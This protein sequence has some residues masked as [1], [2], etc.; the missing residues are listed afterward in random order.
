MRA[1]TNISLKERKSLVLSDFRGVDF[2]SS[3]LR[4]KSNRASKMRNFINEYG[5]NRKRNGWNE[6]H[7]F[8][9]KINGIFEF[10]G[11]TIVYAG[12]TF[13]SIDKGAKIA[14]ITSPK[15]VDLADNRIQ[16][17]LKKG[18]AY[19]IGCGDYLVYN[20]NELRRV[21]DDA[22]TYIPTTTI[23]IDNDAV[24]ND[25]RATLDDVNCLSS[26]RKNRLVGTAGFKLNTPITANTKVDILLETYDLPDTTWN[27][28]WVVNYIEPYTGDNFANESE[29]ASITNRLMYMYYRY[30]ETEVREYGDVFGYI[31]YASGFIEL[32]STVFVNSKITVKYTYNNRK[33]SQTFSGAE[34]TWTLDSKIKADTLVEIV[35]E[36]IESEFQYSEIQDPEYITSLVSY[37]INNNGGDR[38][39]LYKVKKDGEACEPTQCGSIDFKN[40]KITFNCQTAPQIE[41]K[42]NIIVTFYHKTDFSERITKCT[43]GTLFGVD[44]NTNRLFLS[45]NPDYPNMDFHSEEDDFTYFSDLSAAAL[46]SDEVAI[47][48]YSRLSDS[49]LVIHKESN[50]RETTIFYRTGYY[51]TKYDENGNLMSRRAIFPLK[52]G[53]I[54]E[55]CVSTYAC[56]DFAG[57]SLIL[58]PSGVYG[59]VLANNVAT[60]ERYLRERSRLIGEH[61]KRQKNLSEAVGIVYKNRYYLAVDGVCYVA[62]ARYK[63][64]TEDDVDGSYNY[65]WWYWDNIPARVWAVIDEKLYFGTEDGQIC[66]FDDKYTDRTYERIG[67]GKL[68]VGNVTFTFDTTLTISE[69]DKI[70]L[71]ADISV[72]GEHLKGRELYVTDLNKDNQTFK[73]STCLGGSALDFSGNDLT[74]IS[75]RLVNEKNVVAEWCTPVFDLGTNEASKSLLK[76]TLLTEPGINGKL[77][78]GYETRNVNK[79]IAARG[80]T[81]FSFDNLSFENFSFETGFANSYSVKCNQ[82]NFNF[83]MFRFFSDSDSDCCVN[84][85]TAIY[86]INKSNIGVM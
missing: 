23:S 7:K 53:S 42:D 30:E 2:S 18:K 58:S 51:D 61:L 65:E 60:A 3:V 57:D 75:A 31:N 38:A 67:D 33:F 43:F 15:G 69:S 86:K 71:D 50:G 78:F 64:T 77:K 40:G 37:E 72:G 12:T 46:G 83:I 79:L 62:D 63:F 28:G 9:G 11:K 29:S 19:I 21:A 54:G 10:D 17:F 74:G 45:G 22:D 14:T 13:Y 81:P 49:N 35:L 85:L 27:G 39:V 8:V 68:S 32:A 47:K 6:L 20:G 16:A 66:V 76:L 80:I 24:G 44:G 73:V 82:R 56:A 25:V 34:M 1:R 59:V 52:A 55:G 36:T 70:I 41:N 84:S 26:R 5:V 48:G 4:V